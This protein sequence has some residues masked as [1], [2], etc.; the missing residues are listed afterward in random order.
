[1]FTDTEFNQT[2]RLLNNPDRATREQARFTL[3]EARNEAT[4]QLIDLLK[5]GN[6][7]AR[8]EAAQILKATRDPI[9]VDALVEALVDD[10][11]EVH[12]I[13]SEAL[14]AMGHTSILPLLKGI[15]RHFESYRFRQGAYHILHTFERFSTLDEETLS[16]L[17]ALRDIAPDVKAAWAAERAIESL[18]IFAKH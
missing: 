12:W 11:I 15:T 16:V 14:I 9:A 7:H 2:I 10:S 1:M 5:T 6:A 3:I 8:W 18:E 4:P 17:N 13:A